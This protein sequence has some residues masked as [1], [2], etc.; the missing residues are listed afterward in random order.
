MSEE[1][2]CSAAAVHVERRVKLL[3]EHPYVCSGEI[4]IINRGETDTV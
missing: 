2:G 1:V 4:G 3:L